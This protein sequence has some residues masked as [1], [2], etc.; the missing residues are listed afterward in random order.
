MHIEV[1]K[2][3]SSR[4]EDFYS[5]HCE[6]NGE[7]CCNCVAWWVPSWD[8]WDERTKE[9]NR[10]FRDELFSRG[11]YDGYILYVDGTPA[12]WVQCGARDR[13]KKLTSQLSLPPDPLVFAV[14][15]FV[16]ALQFRKQGLAH[17]LL[18]CLLEDL[19][20]KGVSRVQAFPK[21]GEK[22]KD[23]SVWMGPLGLYEKAGFSRVREDEYTVVMERDLAVD[24]SPQSC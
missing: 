18:D 9:E 12:G 21:K 24:L 11:E 13:L 1:R 10:R 17:R 16:I 14:T 15:C 19:K 5:L 22:L 20:A 2:L 23:G 6:K 8:G 7:G 4:T 3:D